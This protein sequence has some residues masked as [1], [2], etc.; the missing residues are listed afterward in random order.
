MVKIES[1]AQGAL[2]LLLREDGGAADCYKQP[3]NCEAVFKNLTSEM[4][5]IV[6]PESMRC[7]KYHYPVKVPFESQKT[8]DTILVQANYTSTGMCTESKLNFTCENGESHLPLPSCNLMMTRHM[9]ASTPKDSVMS[10]EIQFDDEA[11]V[12]ADLA[13]YPGKDDQLF[14]GTEQCPK[15][16]KPVDPLPLSQRCGVVMMVYGEKNPFYFEIVPP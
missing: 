6:L 8:G 3:K 11:V 16:S 7:F 1:E 9:N 4:P 10:F 5:V 2:E 15:P 13:V 12:T 14:S